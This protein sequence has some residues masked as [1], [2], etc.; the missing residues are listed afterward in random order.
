MGKGA[1]FAAIGLMSA[2]SW[3]ETATVTSPDGRNVLKLEVAKE[4]TYQV[5]RDGEAL[6]APSPIALVLDGHAAFGPEAKLAGKTAR[7]GGLCVQ[8][9]LYKKAAVC[10]DG[11]YLT[12]AFE[13]GWGVE[14]AARN[15]GVAYRFTTAL[16]GEVTV[17]DEMATVALSSPGQKLLVNAFDG[18]YRPGKDDPLDQLQQSQESTY[19][20]YAF[21]NLQARAA[22]EALL[23]YPPLVI[24]GEK[25]V[26]AVT[27]S[28]LLDYAGL[29]F[30]I[31]SDFQGFRSEF[32]RYPKTMRYETFGKITGDE[33]SRYRRVLTREDYIAKT[34]GTRTYPWRCFMLADEL[35]QLVACDLV[36]ALAS[37]SKIG[38]ASWVKPGKAA[39]DWWS[40]WQLTGVD[41]RPGCNTATY[42]YFVDFA[43][44]NGLEYVIM[45]EGW[46]KK[47]RILEP[48]DGVDVADVCAYANKKGVGIILWAAWAQFVG[49]EEEVVAHYAKLGAKGFKIDFMDRDDQE[50][51]RF[52]ADFA[53]LC[54][55]YHMVLDY[56]GIYKPT[57][58]S[59]T[60]PNVLNYEGIYG[61]ENN[62]W[63]TENFMPAWDCTA[64]MTRMLAGPMD[65]TPGAMRNC[66]YDDWPAKRKFASAPGTR[67][68]QLAMFTVY[69]APLQMLCDS[70]SQYLQNR[71][72]FDFIRRV[73]TVW[74]DTVA[75]FGEPGKNCAV[76]RKSGEKTWYVG[77]LGGWLDQEVS[78]DT[79]FLGSGEWTMEAFADGLNADLDATDYRH[80]TLVVTAGAPLKV[81]LSPGGGFTARFT[82]GALVR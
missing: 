6:T 81:K 31:R 58:F 1:V 67:V 18:G 11:N 20:F 37:D 14:L 60:Y 5:L 76:A 82:K 41:F 54:A 35:V 75:L 49:R 3:A 51:V 78:I 55:K 16:P 62:K 2:A 48:A 47:L 19:D 32:A 43:A 8:T 36:Y 33:P 39:W 46:S 53:A 63:S 17:R 26:M 56:H 70:P 45:D 34:V 21:S 80:Y 57:G 42:R 40:N 23:H 73:P 44:E 38:D 69:E 61:A 29:N 25:S 66:T 68:H 52:L 15:D 50:M 4:L 72:C 74:S 27:E 59:R 71:E 10:D 77:V 79:S 64:A 7:R 30:R 65:Y 9:P 13:G 12:L 24:Y 22:N 28:D